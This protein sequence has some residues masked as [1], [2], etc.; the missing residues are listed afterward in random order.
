MNIQIYGKQ[1]C[2]GTKKAERFFSER[3]IKYQF[4]DIV[5]YG[6]GRG[7]YLTIKAALG[8]MEALVDKK[9][10]EYEEQFMEHLASGEDA[11]ERLLANPGMI[12]TP[13]VR[14]GKRATAGYQ[15]EIW[16]AWIKG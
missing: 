15:P 12:A 3:N 2:P 1:K 16:K 14:D 7:E 8:G 6:L 9:S 4:V 13:L 11:E 5:R 10:K